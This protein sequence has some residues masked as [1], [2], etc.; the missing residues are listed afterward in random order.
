MQKNKIYCVLFTDENVMTHN[1]LVIGVNISVRASEHENA[2]SDKSCH[3][4]RISFKL[5]V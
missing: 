3:T 2:E 5:Q 4:I 1:C